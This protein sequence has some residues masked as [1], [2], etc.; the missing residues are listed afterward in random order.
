MNTLKTKITVFFVLTTLIIFTTLAMLILQM[1]R[2]DRISD[3]KA[4]LHHVSSEVIE[5]YIAPSLPSKDTGY[6]KRIEPVQALTADKAISNPFFSIVRTPNPKSPPDTVTVTTPLPDGTYFMIGS[7]TKFIDKSLG[8]LAVTLY[9]LFFGAL[10]ILTLLFYLVLRKLLDPMEQ[11]SQACAMIDLEGEPTRFPQTAASVEIEK[12]RYALQSLMDRITFFREKEKQM[13]KETAHQFKTPMAVLKARLDRYSL[14]PSFTK[15]EFIPQANRDIEK[16]LKHLKELLIVHE[17]KVPTDEPSSRIDARSLITELCTYAS[18]LLQ[19][20]SQSVTI[21][22]GGTFA[23]T[24]H[25]KSFQKLILTVLENCINHAPEHS[26]ITVSL[27]PESGE[28]VF[29]NPFSTTI[30]PALFN[31]NLGL[32]IIRELS[33]SLDIGVNVEQTDTRF[34]L[35]LQCTTS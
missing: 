35:A 5:D 24:T 7:D 16:L 25:A 26:T 30:A 8:R 10:G 6:L 9:L 14:D 4:L 11:L 31:S 2:E 12:L 20:K 27:S 22:S 19:R 34:T 21:A 13:F 15:E 3:L 29:E 28:I 17:S 23:L 33:Q 1:E 18:P 32:N